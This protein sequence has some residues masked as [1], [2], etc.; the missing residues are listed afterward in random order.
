MTVAENIALALGYAR[1]GR[2]IDWT[3]TEAAADRA[4]AL[5][6]AEF[7]ASARVSSL[8]RTQKSLVA[9]ARALARTAIFLCWTNPPPAFG[10]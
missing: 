10:R 2:M 8:T 5:V 7:P 9:I 6:D 1:R 3:A 4:L